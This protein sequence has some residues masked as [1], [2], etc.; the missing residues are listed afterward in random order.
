MICEVPPR[1]D[2][3]FANESQ[4]V[5]SNNVFWTQIDAGLGLMMW[6][7][8]HSINLAVHIRCMHDVILGLLDKVTGKV[9]KKYEWNCLFKKIW[10]KLNLM[11]RLFSH[12]QTV[13]SGS[14][15]WFRISF[16]FFRFYLFPCIFPAIEHNITLYAHF[17][18]KWH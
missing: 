5:V 17:V 18:V 15:G 4:L 2:P 10:K 1:S 9:V 8:S 7:W 11:F 6:M 3:F 12:F 16:A 13:T 14:V